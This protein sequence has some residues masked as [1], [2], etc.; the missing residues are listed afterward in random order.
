[1]TTKSGTNE[2]HGTLFE[3]NRNSGYGV[4]CQRQSTWTKAAKLNRYECGGTV[5]GPIWINNTA[6]YPLINDIGVGT[7][8]GNYFQPIN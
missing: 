2:L 8:G 5:G 7:G 3:T 4:A 1:M 6:G